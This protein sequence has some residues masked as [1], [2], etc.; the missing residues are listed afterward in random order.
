MA[1]VKSGWID[2]QEERTGRNELAETQALPYEI[3]TGTAGARKYFLL[4]GSPGTLR[5]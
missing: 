3:S 1:M 4:P 2:V 5:F